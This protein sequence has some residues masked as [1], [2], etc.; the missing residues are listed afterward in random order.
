MVCFQQP[1]LSLATLYAALKKIGNKDA[2]KT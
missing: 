1:I 2:L